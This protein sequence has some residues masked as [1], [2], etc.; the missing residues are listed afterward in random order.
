LTEA[1]IPEFE[2]N[3]DIVVNSIPS[4]GTERLVLNLADPTIDATDDPLNNPHWALGDLRVRQAIELGIDKE[5]INQELLFG[6][7]KVGTNELNNGWAKVELPPSPYDPDQA[8]ALLEEAGWTDEDGDGVR[9]CH[10]CLYGEEDQPL[11]MKFQT[12]T[13]NQLREETEQIIIEMLAEVGIELY[14]ENVPSSVLFGSWASGA[15]RKHGNF[16]IVMYTTND[17]VDPQSQIEGYFASSAIPTEANAGAG[18][19]YSR[20]VNEEADALIKEAGSTPDIEAR[21]AAYQKIMELVSAELPHIYL[22][23]RAEITLSRSNIQNFKVT[24]WSDNTW[25]VEDWAVAE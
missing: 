3:P 13:G 19:N 25:N 18:F 22:Y 14:V 17:G 1:D 10:G 12:T 24:P 4:P 7:A 8:M 6:L 9:E 15:F 16:D 21:K 2:G 20:W 23:D 5:F 11:S